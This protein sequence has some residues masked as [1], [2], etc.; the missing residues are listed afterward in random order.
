MNTLN[1]INTQE[2]NAE[3]KLQKNVRHNTVKIFKCS[4][5]GLTFDRASQLGYHYRSIH[6]GERSQVCQI[7]GKGFFRKADLRTHLNVHLGTNFCICEFCG[8][9]FNHISNLI[10]HCRVHAGVKPYLCSICERR[11]T[12]VSSLV[13][14]KQIIHGIPKESMRQYCS[15]SLISNKSHVAMHASKENETTDNNIKDTYHEK[16]CTELK[17]Q[18]ANRETNAQKDKISSQHNNDV[19]STAVTTYLPFETVIYVT[20][21]QFEEDNLA[22]IENRLSQDYLA[23]I[24]E[25]LQ[26]IDLSTSKTAVSNPPQSDTAGNHE[27]QTQSKDSVIYLHQLDRNSFTFLPRDRGPGDVAREIHSFKEESVANDVGKSLGI[28]ANLPTCDSDKFLHNKQTC[29]EITGEDRKCCD[30]TLNDDNQLYIELSELGLLKFDESRYCGNADL[31]AVKSQH[32]TSIAADDDDDDDDLTYT[33]AQN[34]QGNLARDEENSAAGLSNPGN[35]ALNNNEDPMVQ[36]EAGE[37]FYEFISNLVEKMQDSA[38]GVVENPQ[39]KAEG[40]SSSNV[41]NVGHCPRDSR[42]VTAEKND[43]N[44]TQPALEDLADMN[45]EFSYTQFDFHRDEK[46]FTV[47]CEAERYQR[48]KSLQA[49]YGS[50]PGNLELLENEPHVD[51]D[52]YVETNFEVFERLNYE[53]CGEKFF[54]FVE[55]ADI[56]VES[57]QGSKEQSPMVCLTVQNDGDQLLELL[58]DCQITE[59]EPD[60]VSTATS[61]L[62]EDCSNVLSRD[63]TVGCTTEDKPDFFTLYVESNAPLEENLSSGDDVADPLYTDLMVDNDGVSASDENCKSQEPKRPPEKSDRPE[64]P[65]PSPKK[66]QCSVCKKAFSTAYNYKQ[67]IGIHFA[68]QQ[69]FH[70]KE[71]GV[72]FAWKSTLNKHMASTHSSNWPPKF[73]CGVCPRAY[74]TLSQVNEHVKRDH[75]KQRNHVCDYCGKSF[76]KSFDLKTHSRTHTNERPYA[77]RVCGKRFHHQSHIIRHERTHS[78]ERPYVCVVCQ[79]AFIQPGSLKVHEQKHRQLK[80]DILNY[81]I[82][83]DDPI[84]LMTL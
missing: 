65:R 41:F 16:V 79:K 46:S 76:F 73:V 14:H 75:L 35:V 18:N 24:E 23:G 31:D 54:E 6:L 64:K 61:K 53:N 8:R 58:Q 84:A 15:S 68:D 10:R 13:R 48:E 72:S 49:A 2:T 38:S 67:H 42:G 17:C 47:L 40:P 7:C 55:V 37:Q 5:C 83:E 26:S 39:D 81:Q 56:G 60:F 28:G 71:C 3:M 4:E 25:K 12:Q 50:H 80:M 27:T 9:K 44:A 11:F 57:S 74:S 77:C 1:N 29:K 63:K 82:D 19:N 22:E 30:K 59:Q 70:C 62:G 66:Y 33:S 36:T 21:K 20:S 34:H 51:F 43:R 78:G 45:N 69:K 52:K 32:S